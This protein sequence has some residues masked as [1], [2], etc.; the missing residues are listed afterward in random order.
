MNNEQTK[1]GGVFTFKHIRNGEVIDQWDE[2]NIVTDEGLNYI[3]DSALSGATANTSH[4][5]GLFKNNYSPIST[6]VMAT[7]PGAGVANEANSEYNEASRPTW[8]E[9]GVSAKTITNSASPATFTFN[10]SVTIYGAF[11]SS[12]S[13]KAGTSGVLVSAAKFSAARSMLNADQL[14]ITYTLSAS[15]S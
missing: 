7:F 13:T 5:I 14:Q 10:T 15:S 2:H 3:L 6:N 8:T 1:F 9:A 12:S 11:L 4:Y